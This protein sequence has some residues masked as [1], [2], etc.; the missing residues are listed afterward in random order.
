MSCTERIC[1]V[2]R[3]GA[4][5]LL[6]NNYTLLSGVCVSEIQFAVKLL[7]STCQL[8]RYMHELTTWLLTFLLLFKTVHYLKWFDASCNPSKFFNITR[9]YVDLLHFVVCL[10][11]NTPTTVNSSVH[12]L[13]NR[14]RI[15]CSSARIPSSWTLHSAALRGEIHCIHLPHLLCIRHRRN[16]KN[17]FSSSTTNKCHQHQV[18]GLCHKLWRQLS[19]FPEHCDYVE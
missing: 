4:V 3:N 9:T 6:E 5:R 8:E 1:R 7:S 10:K 16:L 17:N 14:K 2:A 18:E 19:T 13:L 15:T 12:L 11:H